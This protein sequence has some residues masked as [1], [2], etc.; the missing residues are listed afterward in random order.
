MFDKKVLKMLVDLENLGKPKTGLAKLSSKWFSFKL[1][2]IRFLKK[3]INHKLS[4]KWYLVIGANDI[5]YVSIKKNKAHK[6]L[7]CTIELETKDKYIPFLNGLNYFCVSGESYKYRNKTEALE[8]QIE[9][10]KRERDHYRDYSFKK[11]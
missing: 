4:R 6:M 5:S 2:Y 7:D 10:L 8:K 3:Y 9:Y 1:H 11:R